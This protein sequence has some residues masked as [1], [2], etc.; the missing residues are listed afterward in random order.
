[1]DRVEVGI[2]VSAKSLSVAVS[3]NGTGSVCSEFS[4]DREGH[5]RLIRYI[6]KRARQ[7][8]VCLEAT[9]VYGLDLAMALDRAG[10]EVMVANP[11]VIAS[12]GSAL[13]QRSKTDAL[14]AE[15]ILQYLQRMEFVRWTAPS[16]KR[17]ELRAIMRRVRSLKMTLVQEKNR[18][19][20]ADAAEALTRV[21]SHDIKVNI[22]HLQRRIERLE[23]QAQALVVEDRELAGMFSQLQSIVG[24]G[25]TSGLQILAEISLLPPDMTGPQLVAHAGLDPRQCQSGSTVHKPARVSKAGNKHLRAALFYPAMVAVRHDANVRAFH[26]ALLARGKHQIQAYVAVMRKLLHV[27]VGMRRA[28]TLYDSTRFYRRAA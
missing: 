17:F 2:D 6:K 21:I 22:R 10:V 16:A 19:H 27:I 12:F 1:M 5:Q 7:I 23:A 26:Q 18:L 14:D 8:R 9:G 11:R 28:G 4:N 24:I 3:R 25:T 20:A 15:T 13:L